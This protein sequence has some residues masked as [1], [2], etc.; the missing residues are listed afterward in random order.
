[1][2]DYKVKPSNLN[3]LSPEALDKFLKKE[4][5]NINRFNNFYKSQTG[6]TFITPVSEPKKKSKKTVAC[7]FDS[8]ELDRLNVTMKTLGYKDYSNTI[9]DCLDYSYNNRIK[10]YK[11]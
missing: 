4:K 5:I 9:R 1:M 3:Q 11:K 2:N 10:R 7:R 8:E 6:K